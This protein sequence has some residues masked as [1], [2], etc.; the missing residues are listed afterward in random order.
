MNLIDLSDIFLELKE[1]MIQKSK[2]QLLVLTFLF[3]FYS[4]VQISSPSFAQNSPSTPE[5]KQEQPELDKPHS[6][7]NIDYGNSSNYQNE[8]PQYG[9][10]E[11]GSGQYQEPGFRRFRPLRRRNLRPYS[12][13]GQPYGN[14]YGYANQGGPQGYNEN[15]YHISPSRYYG[16]AAY[17][18]GSPYRARPNVVYAPQGTM[19]PMR[20]Q[21]AIST[22]VAQAGDLIQGQISQMVSLG[23]RG[24]IPAGTQVVGEVSRSTKGRRLSRSGLLS[25]E[26]TSLR[27]PSGK[28]V[29]IQAHLVGNISKY[30]N[31]GQ[32]NQNVYR[33]EGWGTKFGQL[34]LRGAGGA[35]LGAA[36]GTGL[37][38]IAG[39]G[40]GVG[41]GAWG[42]AAIGGGIGAA[43][44]LLRKGRD[45]II[46]SGTEV[47][48]QLDSQAAIPSF[49]QGD[50][51]RYGG[52]Y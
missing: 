38:A 42:G 8:R 9:Y 16:T 28:Q 35:G 11:E 19:L 40:R 43:D 51:G 5:L 48:I 2:I 4:F 45:V 23:G 37:G 24:Y 20:L 52:T 21:T 30:K 46:P 1:D 22:Q 14:G 18:A 26:F 49:A 47:E 33:G 29:P 7:Q 36:L 10:G 32:G 12:Y 13:Q 34:L 25:I 44:M 50:N 41:R 6:N 39:G 17:Q 27:L 3:L 15:H 31:K